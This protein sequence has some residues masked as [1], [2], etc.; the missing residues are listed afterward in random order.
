MDG[1]MYPATPAGAA[2][3]TT[4]IYAGVG[5]PDNAGGINGDF[6]LRS[7]GTVGSNIYKKAGGLWAAIL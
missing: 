7:D 1:P 2:Q 6:Y 3:V 4:S 5:V